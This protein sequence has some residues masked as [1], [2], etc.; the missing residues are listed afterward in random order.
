MWGSLTLF[1][2]RFQMF[3]PRGLSSRSVKLTAHIHLVLSLGMSG[4]LPPPF[5]TSRVTTYTADSNLRSNKDLLVVNWTSLSAFDI[6]CGL[7]HPPLQI[8]RHG[9]SNSETR[10]FDIEA[11]NGDRASCWERVDLCGKFFGFCRGDL[12][13]FILITRCGNANIIDCINVVVCLAYWLNEVCMWNTNI[14]L[15]P[16]NDQ[17][18]P[19]FL[20]LCVYFNS[21]HVSSILVLIIRRIICINTTSGMCH[22]V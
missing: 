15:V 16:V 5:M 6:A 17:L 18:N 2:N 19:Q 3:F 13:H 4:V 21:L 10:V 1:L 11:A 22:S 12:N 14:Y 7:C 8:C 20:F 9:N